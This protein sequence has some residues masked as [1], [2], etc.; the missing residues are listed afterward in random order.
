MAGGIAEPRYRAIDVSRIGG[1][2]LIGRLLHRVNLGRRG[3][4][5]ALQ[6]TSFFFLLAAFFSG[7][8]LG[9]AF[10]QTQFSPMN[11]LFFL[12]S[13]QR[14]ARRPSRISQRRQIN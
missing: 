14:R 3:F 8:K 6:F 11:L 2:A 12:R 1:H 9:T 10:L 7:L 13:L 5:H 4:F